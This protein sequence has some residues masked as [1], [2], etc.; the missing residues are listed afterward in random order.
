M[1]PNAQMM[2]AIDLLARLIASTSTVGVDPL[3]FGTAAS[4]ESQG[5]HGVSAELELPS[6]DR[7]RVVVEWLGDREGDAG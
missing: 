5:D 2:G 7:Y 6:G 1:I 4:V 3:S